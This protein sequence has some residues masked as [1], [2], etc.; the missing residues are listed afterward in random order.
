MQQWP[1][2]WTR[3]RRSRRRTGNGIQIWCDCGEQ[4]CWLW[5][6]RRLRTNCLASNPNFELSFY[7]Q[8]LLHQWDPKKETAISVRK[9][10]SFH[11]PLWSSRR[12]KKLILPALA[13]WSIHGQAFYFRFEPKRNWSIKMLLHTAYT[14]GL[15][16]HVRC[17]GTQPHF[18]RTSLQFVLKHVQ[19]QSLHNK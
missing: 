11:K 19:N 17:T 9:G 7:L 16:I 8:L 10:L 18:S 12:A 3:V 13:Y 15:H 6:R 4:N 1:A 5:P 2:V 14:Y